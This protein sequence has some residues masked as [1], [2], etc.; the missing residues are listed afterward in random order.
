M[1]STIMFAER[2]AKTTS[3][4][5][6]L[7]LYFQIK[8]L[9]ETL[10][11]SSIIVTYEGHAWERLAFAAAR[12]VNPSIRCIGYQHAILFPR[13]HAIKRLLSPHFDPDVILTA[14][15]VTRDILRK[16]IPDS[17]I[18]I[19]TCGTHRFRYHDTNS[20]LNK[21]QLEMAQCLVLPDGNMSEC[22]KIFDFIFKAA[23]LAPNLKFIIRTH[24]LI[25]Y[26]KIAKD[27]RRFRK[28][29]KN[30]EI[31][32]RG[33]EEDFARCRWAIYRG[34]S[35]AIYAVVAGL[36]PFY[37]AEKDELSIDPLYSLKGWR[38]ITNTPEDFARKIESD[39]KSN[40][41]NLELEWSIARKFCLNYFQQI[42]VNVFAGAIKGTL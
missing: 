14:G 25:T 32:T 22:V 36:R 1:Y 7:G 31:S 38:L 11:P 2:H 29:P 19:K 42:D 21:T 34:S 18:Q 35:A 10:Q 37:I 8:R 9:V 16:A 20:L 6:T 17:S 15:D 40:L 28:P 5:I 3:S 30:I 13:Q 27:I 39:M 23:I 41:K 4:I 12:D 24:P 33:I 26:E